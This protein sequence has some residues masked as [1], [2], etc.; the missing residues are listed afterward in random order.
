M[1]TVQL[2]LLENTNP[3]FPVTVCLKFHLGNSLSS[4]LTA[5]SAAVIL[6]IS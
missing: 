5:A 6:A 1:D 3:S 4:T 2:D